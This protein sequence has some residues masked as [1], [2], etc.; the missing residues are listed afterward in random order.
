MPERVSFRRRNSDGIRDK[1]VVGG[2]RITV[3][4]MKF[5][6]AISILVS[7][8]A[9]APFFLHPAFT[10]PPSAASKQVSENIVEKFYGTPMRDMN[11]SKGIA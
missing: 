9:S 4:L 1:S 10:L 7:F 5:V 3:I 6:P 11:R 2:E 8:M